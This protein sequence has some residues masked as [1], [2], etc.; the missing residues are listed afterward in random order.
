[1]VTS[2]FWLELSV[3]RSVRNRF[4]RHSTRVRR[5]A[6]RISDVLAA[7]SVTIGHAA[8]LHDIGKVAIT[9]EILLRPGPLTP[10]EY[11]IVQ[12]HVLSGAWLCRADPRVAELVRHHHER[13]DGSGYPD[14][15]EAEA[16]PLGARIL[17]VCDVYDTI[18]KDVRPYA[19]SRNHAEAVVEIRRNAGTQFDPEVVSAFDQF[20]ARA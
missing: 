17:A 12:T 15:L 18:C 20:A 8:L 13:W 19:D 9:P 5:M 4:L 14:G 6:M 1:M 16:I 11:K 7:D 2:Q 10:M 3:N